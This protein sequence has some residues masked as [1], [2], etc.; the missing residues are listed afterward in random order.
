MRHTAAFIHSNNDPSLYGFDR[1]WSR[2]L[3]ADGTFFELRFDFSAAPPSFSPGYAGTGNPESRVYV[4]ARH[5]RD[6][7]TGKGQVLAAFAPR[8]DGGLLTSMVSRKQRDS[9]NGTIGTNPAYPYKGLEPHGGKDSSTPPDYCGFERDPFVPLENE[10]TSDSDEY[11]SSWRH[12]LRLAKEAATRA[13]DLGQKIIDLGLQKDL[14]RESAGDKLAQI[15]GDYSA[16]GEVPFNTAKG[17]VGESPTDKGLNACLN[18]KR[19]DIVFLTTVPKALAVLKQPASSTWI[20][21]N[22]LRCNLPVHSENPL[23]DSTKHAE[24]TFDGLGI[25]E[26]VDLQL[27][28]DQ[29]CEHP[30]FQ[31]DILPGAG[32]STFI[33]Q[34]ISNEPWVSAA[35]LRSILAQLELRVAA[36]GSWQLLS[37]GSQIMYSG[38]P[39][40]SSS[41][42]PRCLQNPF[43]EDYCG[44]GQSPG[45][46]PTANEL[47]VYFDRLFRRDLVSY[48]MSSPTQ[49]LWRVQGAL[50]MLGALAG[51]V[52]GGLFSGFVPAANLNGGGWSDTDMVPLATVYGEGRFSGSPLLW[53]QNA[54]ASVPNPFQ[55]LTDSDIKIV[56]GNEPIPLGR[57]DYSGT[58][59]PSWLKGIYAA[60]FGR[61]LHVP[62]RSVSYTPYPAVVKEDKLGLWLM[63]QGDGMNGMKCPALY[64]IPSNPSAKYTA[65]AGVVAEAKMNTW[66]CDTE[67]NL[68]VASGAVT[69]SKSSF[70]SVNTGSGNCA[71]TMGDSPFT[72]EANQRECLFES[73]IF[74]MFFWAG[75]SRRRPMLCSPNERMTVFVN[76]YASKDVPCTM[77]TE[78]IQALGLG[79]SLSRRGLLPPPTDPPAINTVDDLPKLERWLGELEKLS[80]LA[81][82]RLYLQNVPERVIAD[83]KT[84]A[85]GTGS[86]K[87]THGQLV[88]ELEAAIQQFGQAWPQMGANFAKI[89][90][91]I[92]GARLQIDIN[93]KEFQ[94]GEQ[95]IVIQ[96]WQA[97]SKMAQ[98]LANAAAS[99]GFSDETF[100]P[101]A[102]VAKTVAA[103]VDYLAFVAELEALDNIQQL[104]GE[105]AG[106]KTA[107]ALNALEDQTSGL[108]ANAASALAELRKLTASAASLSEALRMSEI[109]A[110][111]EAAM[112]AGASF[113]VSDGDV[114]EFP[115]NI[116]LN[117]QYDV[118]TKRYEAAFKEARYLA[119]VAQIAVEQRLGRRL[120]S[121]TQDIGPLE[122]P[123]KWPPVCSLSGVN[124]EKLRDVVVPNGGFTDAD[125]GL[126]SGEFADMFIGDW[127]DRLEKFVEFYNMEY[128]SHD[129]DDIA[130]ISLRDELLGPNGMCMKSSPNLLLYSSDMTG[131]HVVS[132]DANNLTV[133]GWIRR[134]CTSVESRCL[135]LA[136]PATLNPMPDPPK[137]GGSAG[138]MTWLQELPASSITDPIELDLISTTPS[139]AGIVYQEVELE[140]KKYTLSWWD[141]GRDAAGQAAA[142]PKYAVS[143]YDAQ[144]NP[145]TGL[146]YTPHAPAAADAGGGAAEGWSDRREFALSIASSGKYY[147]A[148][149]ASAGTNDPGNVVIANVQLEAAS[150]ATPYVANGSSPLVLN[151]NCIAGNPTE[152]QKAFKYICDAAGICFYEL[153]APFTVST[154]LL[155]SGNSNL[156]GKIA[157]GNFNYRHITVA[158]NLVGSG[159]LDCS[160]ETTSSCY[161]SGYVEYSLDHTAFDVEVLS[162][163]KPKE[164]Q[165]FNFGLGSINRGKGLAAER[166]I[167]LPLGSVDQALLSQPAFEKSEYM[168]RPLDGS[169]TMRIYDKPSL[170]WNNLEDIQF[171]LK[172]RYWSRIQPY[173]SP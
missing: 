153:A 45:P 31:A 68:K 142:A 42:W 85:V 39:S 24:I 88:L 108:Y 14:R 70:A 168:G 115:V 143:V 36:D 53:L 48:S 111:Y 150:V 147:V 124:Y 132:D 51:E 159:V 104:Q 38:D 130:V 91:T 136:I 18:E 54:P 32:V 92:E 129:G 110:Q 46:G 173:P 73:G 64:G 22:V 145:V 164:A 116:V 144:W 10:L 3:G 28:S 134:P 2:I 123:S 74:N 58:H 109:N 127:V 103:G 89:R 79:C 77:A 160:L 93:S 56:G 34:D 128:P 29:N 86:L 65:A 118:T 87:G 152:L 94:I 106:T 151:T 140:A 59:A 9:F 60:Q 169:Y 113:M 50:W 154:N 125:G 5:E 37:G 121:F 98:S 1:T 149:A 122:A 166:F 4:I 102:G 23:C 21:S 137:A 170:R 40:S 44:W 82:S 66:T 55:E 83:F 71:A 119:Y 6:A 120:S 26:H 17:T 72:V 69:F 8:T 156:I 163:E 7:P 15:C 158:L 157:K 95:Q 101:V 126:N 63:N 35:V 96:R 19:S 161:G 167:T 20:R 138:G 47:S 80:N 43:I 78:L 30:G 16:L 13:D 162:H 27:P 171:V 117:R 62:A 105:L 81:L 146:T 33:M 52:P 112:G 114:V 135:S 90:T 131:Q 172:Y 76:S 84:G 67:A 100:N 148:F 75:T 99:W 141:H 49:M 57:F 97:H 139:P 12:Y 41:L 133:K 11:E 155:D 107:A 25:S 61:Y 165:K